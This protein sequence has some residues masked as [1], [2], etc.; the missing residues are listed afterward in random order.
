MLKGGAPQ[1]S[2]TFNT[3][4]AGQTAEQVSADRT[5]ET[6]TKSNFEQD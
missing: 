6:K 5:E 3:P 2:D 4:T 1:K